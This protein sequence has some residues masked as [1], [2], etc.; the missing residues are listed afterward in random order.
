[1]MMRKNGAMYK[2]PMER[3]SLGFNVGYN[4]FNSY[5]NTSLVL[6]F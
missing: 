1:M 5:K 3:N 4:G 6:L 2:P